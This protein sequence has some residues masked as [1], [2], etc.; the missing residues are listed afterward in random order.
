MRDQQVIILLVAVLISVL[1]QKAPS[2]L[3][4]LWFCADDGCLW[5]TEPNYSNANW[6]INR[7]DG[8]TTPNVVSFAFLDPIALLRQTTDSTFLNGVPR[9]MTSQAVSYF[10]NKGIVVQFSIGGYSYTPNWD[11]ALSQ[12][13]SQ[14]AINVA[15]VAK[16]FGVGIEIDYESD[17]PNSN[18]IDT[19]VKKY[20]S[21][22]PYGEDGPSL[23]TVDVG[24]GTG[25]LTQISVLASQWLNQSLI[26]WENAMVAG[27]PDLTADYFE[28]YWQEHLD[29]SAYDGVPPVPGDQLTGALWC[30][31]WATE[32]KVYDGSTLQQVM[33]W[34]ESHKMRGIFF[35]T[36]GCPAPPSDCAV[37][38][39]GIQQ[40]SIEFL[41]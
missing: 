41:G 33:P 24:A 40:G 34:V 13:P 9:G 5:A 12:N 11:S 6:I 31:Y 15:Q 36:A 14:L 20:R 18:G 3:Y 35:W 32:C 37:N 28:M 2:Q 25:Y 21:I 29:G 19:F 26:N 30:S 22:I 17:G 7:G 1:G 39:T 10:K 38:C 23:L 8:K 4:G 16:Q 27:S